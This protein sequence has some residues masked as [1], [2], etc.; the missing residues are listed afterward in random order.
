LVYHL[1]GVPRVAQNEVNLYAWVGTQMHVGMER[2]CKALNRRTERGRF[3]TE[4]R[5]T[6]PVTAEVSITGSCDAYDTLTYTAIDWKS[7]GTSKPSAATRDK[8][9]TQLLPYGLGLILAGKPVEN[10]AVV[11]IPRN[12][13]LSEIEVDTRP[14]DH[15]AAEALLRRYEALITAAAAGPTVLPLVPVAHD[16]RFCPWWLPGWPGD[17]T[18]ACPGVQEPTKTPGDVPVETQPNPTQ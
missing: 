2:A 11:Y 1:L 7:H 6:V 5:V 8:H 17:L 14:F 15:D 16:C 9:H 12:G 4:V 10:T 18:E 13:T 3:L